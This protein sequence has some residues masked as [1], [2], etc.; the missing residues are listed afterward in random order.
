[1]NSLVFEDFEIATTDYLSET[2][3]GGLLLG[4]LGAAAGG[5]GGFFTGGV[6]GAAV[7]TVTL[8]VVGTIAGTTAGAIGVAA[9]VAAT[10]GIAGASVNTWG[11]WI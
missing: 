3:A 7:G 6:A 4:V 10:L 1:M 9:P 11:K 5:V 2:E 8:P